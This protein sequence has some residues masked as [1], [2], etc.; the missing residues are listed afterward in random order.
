MLVSEIGGRLSTFSKTAD[1]QNPDLLLSIDDSSIWHATVHPRYSSNGLL[2]V[3]YSKAGQTYVSRFRVTGIP[4]QADPETEEILL[5]W[6]A[7]GHNGGCLQFGTDGMLYIST[8][9]GSGPNP[10]DGRTAAQDLSNLFGCVLRIDVDRQPQKESELK[11]VIPEDNPFQQTPGARPEIW[12]YGL[13]NPWKFGVDQKTGEIFAADNGWETW[14]SVHRIVRGGN[15]GWPIMEGRAVLRSEVKQ[16][17]TPIRPPVKDHHHSEAN[18]VIGGPVYRGSRLPD[19]DGTFVYGDYITGTIWGVKADGGDTYTQTTLVDT[20]QRITAFAEGSAGELFVLDYDYTGQIYELVP[21]DVPDRSQKFPR[22][23]SQTGLFTSLQNLTPAPGVVPYSV[24]VERWLDG[25]Q[26][27]RWVAVPGTGSIT[28]QQGEIP[29]DYPEGTV[30][31]KHVSLDPGDGQDAIPVETQILHY[32]QGRWNPYSYVWDSDLSGNSPG[33]DATLAGPGGASRQ[34]V[35]GLDAAGN[36]L[37]PVRKINAE[38][39]CRMCHNA[40]SGFVLGFQL[41][42]LNRATTTP[43]AGRQLDSLAE[44]KV[45]AARPRL[46]VNHPGRLVDPHDTSQ[47]LE[48][49]ARS[50]LHGNCSSCHHPGGNAIVS[51]YL[52]R[53]LPFDELRTDKGTGIGTFGMRNARLIVPGDPYRSVLFYRMSKLGYARM[54]YIGSDVVD[55]RGVALIEKWIRSMPHTDTEEDSLP[56]NAGSLDQRVLSE[57]EAG[58][59]PIRRGLPAEGHD[60]EG[61]GRLLK[62]T[63]GAL[64]LAAGIHSGAFLKIDTRHAYE[65][66]GSDI[67]GLFA[68]F[69]PESERRRTLGRNVDAQQLLSL[70]GDAGRGRLIFY[71]DGARCRNCHDLNDA[72]KSTGPTLTEI[73]KKYKRRSELLQQILQPSLK[74]DEK[75]ATWIVI[76]QTGQVHSGLIVS[77]TDDQVVLKTNGQKTVQLARTEIEEIQKSPKSLMPEAILS[78]LTAQEAADLIAWFGSDG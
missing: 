38:N 62:S 66:T 57:L 53:A 14:E 42:Q 28:L 68:T 61:I 23:L 2:F 33:P 18:S 39:E 7:G 56:V 8:G 31:V 19:L 34:V 75:F 65:S 67:R 17:P 9:D 25:F 48:D 32:D 51:F 52:H 22:K 20:D 41:N 54:P 29:A 6:P 70:K 60:P 16:G 11:Y 47:R 72:A 43:P 10:P 49:R 46:P 27:H 59:I 44:Q 12:S 78:D 36:S 5:T 1:V 26:S 13:R 30:F 24:T 76:T 73:R 63:E 71:S 55:S 15:C 40:G 45:L 64:A 50:Y 35:H 69:I 4:P 37:G 58:S 3:C 74:V 77:Q 21:S